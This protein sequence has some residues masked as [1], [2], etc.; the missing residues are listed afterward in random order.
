MK[1]SWLIKKTY[2]FATLQVGM[3]RF[4]RA[5]FRITNMFFFT[6]EKNHD[7]F[8][9]TCCLYSYKKQ[10]NKMI[11]FIY[12]VIFIKYYFSMEIHINRGN[13]KSKY[14]KNWQNIK[15]V[16]YIFHL[17]QILF[18]LYVSLL[19]KYFFLYFLQKPINSGY[20]LEDYHQKKCR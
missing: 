20:I 18:F 3:P 12:T 5:F 13:F 9:L 15:I 1:N 6:S 19:F 11:I 10:P 2:F 14:A 8:F 16:A 7:Q 4:V 17:A